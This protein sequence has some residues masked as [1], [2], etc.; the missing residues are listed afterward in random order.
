MKQSFWGVVV[1]PGIKV[2][3]ESPDDYYTI[4]TGV[5]LPEYEQSNVGE[6][7]ILKGTVRTTVID[8]IDPEKESD[9]ETIT[10]TNFAYLTPEK[11]EYVKMNHVFSPLSKVELEVIG[12]HTVHVS[13]KYLPVD[14][15]GE[16]EDFPDFDD[17]DYDLNDAELTEK[18][19]QK[20]IQ[21]PK[22]EEDDANIEQIA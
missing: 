1:S 16:E 7:S 18:L 10:K 13:G 11:T 19:K 9:P 6:S 22:Y 14:H 15:S 21:K 4:I 8:K 20:Y 12:P 2:E 3:L 17:S 5:A